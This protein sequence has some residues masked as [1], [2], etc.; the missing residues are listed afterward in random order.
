MRLLELVGKESEGSRFD[1]LLAVV[2]SAGANAAILAIINTAVKTVSYESVNFRYLI[3]FAVAIALYTVGLKYTFDRATVIF[4]GVLHRIR[5]RVAA[6]IANADLAAVD[7]IG[8]SEILQRLAQSTTVISE[9]QGLLTAA[10]HSSIMVVFSAIYVATLSFAAFVTVLIFVGAGTLI[11]IGKEKA[12]RKNIEK[13]SRAEIRFFG[14]AAHLVDG[15]KEVKL[16]QRRRTELVEDII[17]ISGAVR[18]LKTKTTDLYNE[19]AIFSQCFFYVLIGAV[20]FLLPRLIETYSEVVSQLIAAILFMI[21]PLS[22][23]VSG[24]PALSRANVAA[25]SI[26]RLEKQLEQIASG[27]LDAAAEAED[28]KVTPFPFCRRIQLSEAEFRYTDKGRGS[29]FSVGP[30]SHEI[31]KGEV[32]FIVGGNGSGKSTL[33][34]LITG[35]YEPS[36]GEIRVDGQPVNWRDIQKYRE[37][38][39]AIFSDF[40][41]FEK[42]YGLSGAGAPMIAELLESMQ[43]AHKTEFR[44]GRFTTLELSTGQKKRLA[45]IV[46]MLEDRPIVVFDE[47][48]ADQDPEFRKYFYEV[49]LRDLRDRGKTVIAVT[50]DDHYFMHCDTLIKMDLGAVEYVRAMGGPATTG[51]RRD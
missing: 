40:H 13:S 38:F 23:V 9:S 11:F 32:I 29:S 37:M 31:K 25:E 27:D 3:M 45:L 47:W 34:K 21:G 51:A 43:I 39:S 7:A 36:G 14:S 6:Q 17:G 18:V 35:L 5:S 22:T 41:L 48:A 28:A 16:N 12:I 10:L 33:L 49:L 4:E 44:N 24:L 42:L 50:H 19:N 20:V 30:I 8:K 1:I 26:E 2:V 15:L 46:L